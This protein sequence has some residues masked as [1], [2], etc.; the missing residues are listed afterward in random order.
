MTGAILNHRKGRVYLS[1]TV[2]KLNYNFLYEELYD[3]LFLS[4]S[5]NT[6]NKSVLISYKAFHFIKCEEGI[7]KVKPELL[8]DETDFYHPNP[9]S[10]THLTLPTNREV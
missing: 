1:K 7:S 9:V 3:E 2:L 8:D 10:Y 6:F 4:V 5:K